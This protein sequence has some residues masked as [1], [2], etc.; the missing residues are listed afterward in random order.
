MLQDYY[1]KHNLEMKPYEYYL[2]EFQNVNPEGVTSRLDIPF[3]D[4]S[5]SFIIKFMQNTYTIS[6]PEFE[7]HC[8]DKSDK[9]AILCNDIHAK[10]LMLRYFS[11]G[12]VYKRQSLFLRGYGKLEEQTMTSYLIEKRDLTI[13]SL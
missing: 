9:D 13:L 8:I 7:I 2:A 5:K 10:I 12:D 1:E 6:Y 11:E 4:N 3:D